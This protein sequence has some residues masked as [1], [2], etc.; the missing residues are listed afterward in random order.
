VAKRDWFCFER[1]GILGGMLLM[2]GTFLNL[3]GQV[4]TSGSPARGE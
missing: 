4:G 2:V 1:C 3:T